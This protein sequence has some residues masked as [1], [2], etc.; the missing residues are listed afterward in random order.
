MVLVSVLGVDESLEILRES[1]DWGECEF[2][3]KSVYLLKKSEK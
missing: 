3:W 2:L 1:E